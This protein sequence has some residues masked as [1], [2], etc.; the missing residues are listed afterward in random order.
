M[1]LWTLQ[2]PAVLE[3]IETLGVYHAHD[4][5]IEF[6]PSG[7]TACSHTH[8]AYTWYVQQMTERIGAP[9]EGIHYPIW[10][11]AKHQNR[12]DGK[13]DMRFDRW[14]Y[15]G[16]ICRLRLEI[17]TPRILLSDFDDWH[18]VLNY[19]YLA[20]S[21]Q[22]HNNFEHWCEKR[23][24][25]FNDPSNWSKDLPLLRE[26]RQMIETS[27]ERIFDIDRKDNGSWRLP[28]IMRTLQATFWE[29]RKD[30]IVSIERFQGAL[31]S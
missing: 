18:H 25:S 30:D 1:E 26:V 27:W 23:G 15:S 20:L 4:E 8:Y 19:S 31:K 22:D 7:D 28:F 2:H 29:L 5:L 21:E 12:V 3:E 11:F 10:A 9:P 14:F 16:E 13:M 17:D 6:P 24:I